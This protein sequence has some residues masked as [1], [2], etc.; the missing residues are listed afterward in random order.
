MV[1]AKK[2]RPLVKKEDGQNNEQVGAQAA[3]KVTHAKKRQPLVKIE[4]GQNNQQPQVNVMWFRNDLRL[5]DNRALIAASEPV[6]GVHPVLLPLYIYDTTAT[7]L[8]GV[9][10][11]SKWWLHH[12]L[13]AL[14]KSLQAS[15]CGPLILRKGDPEQILKSLCS[16]LGVRKVCFSTHYEPSIYTRD[17]EVIAPSLQEL[18]VDAEGYR[19]QL[20]IEP[21]EVKNRAGSYFKVFTPFWRSCLASECFLSEPMPAPVDN[22]KAA[23]YKAWDKKDLIQSDLLSTWELL[24]TKPDWSTTI[25]KK[26]VPGELAAKK[27]LEQFVC[28]EKTKLFGGISHYDTQRDY[29]A[30]EKGTSRMSAHLHFGEVSPATVFTM[31]QNSTGAGGLDISGDIKKYNAELGWREFAY[32]LHFHFRDLDWKPFQG[33]F[34]KMK[35]SHDRKPDSAN[36]QLNKWQKGQTGYPIVDAAMRELWAT[37]WMHNRCRMIV[38]SFLTK[39]LL[40]N[41]VY[42]AAWF[43]DTLVDHDLASNSAGWQWIAGTGADASPYFRIFNPITQSHKFDADGKYIRKWVPELSKVPS[44]FI[45]EPWKLDAA[46]LQSYGVVLGETYPKPMVDHQKARERA[47]GPKGYGVLK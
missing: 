3:S 8:N 23:S 25:A 7:G 27:K 40:I 47:L 30:N 45:H 29:M 34:E 6:G 5:E 16:E 2:Q 46:A 43:W 21:E 44:K 19:G 17:T 20:L 33:K 37:G 38:G 15:G 36:K 18:G 31:V 32:Y 28:N 42:G 41:W 24:P 26:W 35:W 39:H 4:D 11:A 12:S 10:G 22:L 13:T 14:S 1:Q 9:G